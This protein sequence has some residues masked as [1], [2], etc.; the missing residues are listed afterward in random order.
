M[1]VMHGAKTLPRLLETALVER[2]RVMPAAVI[3]GA[4]QAGKS[5]LVA[6]RTPGKRRYTSLDD[7]DVLDAARH[8]P[9]T[10]VGGRGAVTLNEV[11]RE[12][13]ILAADVPAAPWWKVF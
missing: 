11:Q 4:R 9:E 6:T 13:S 5:T 10:L 2:L 1:I 12:P 3:T 7:L 8:D